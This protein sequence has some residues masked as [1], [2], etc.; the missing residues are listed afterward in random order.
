[1]DQAQADRK[2]I[3]KLARGR[4]AAPLAYALLGLAFLHMWL[5]QPDVSDAVF[6]SLLILIAFGI[7]Q[8]DRHRAMARELVRLRQRLPRQ[9]SDRARSSDSAHVTSSD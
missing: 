4:S 8:A 6:T 1:M 3:G 2:Q 9:T 7:A 5:V